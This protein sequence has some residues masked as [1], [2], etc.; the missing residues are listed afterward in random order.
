MSHIA[1]RP[2]VRLG[3]LGA[4]VGALAVAA[5]PA[6]AV[7]P[8]LG[9]Q[10]GVMLGEHVRAQDATFGAPVAPASGRVLRAEPPLSAT[11]RATCGDGSKPEPGIQGRVPPGADPAGYRCNI[12]QLGHEGTAGGFKVERYVDAAG[13]ECAYYDTTLLFPTNLLSATLSA[14]LTGVAVLD[15]SDPARPVRTAT[16]V[17]PA[18]QSPHESLV[19]NQKRGIVAAVLGNPAFGPGVVDLYDASKDCRHPVLQSSLP[20]GVLGHESGFS[21]DGNTFY[22]TSIGTGQVTAV[23]VSNPQIPRILWIGNY[24]SHG[25]SLNDAGTRAYVAASQGLIVLDTS[26]IQA[27]KPNPQVREVSRL[28][29]TS[30]TIPQNA[31]PVT[32]GGR[33][34]LVEIDEFA[35]DASGNITGL[36]S[37]VGAGRIIDISDERAPRVVSNLRLAVNQPEHRAAL[38]GDAGTSLPVQ[39]YA[40]H[41][42]GVP[43]AVEP[44]IVACSF[45]AS[46]LRVFDIRDPLAPKEIAYFVAPL[47]NLGGSPVPAEVS[48]FAM[49]RPSFVPARGEIWYSD[50]NSGFYAVRVA[51]DVWPF[52]GAGALG[53]PSAGRCVSRRAFTIHLRQPRGRRLASARVFVDGRRVKVV[54]GARTTARIDL[55]GLPRGT[56][57]VRV[58]AKTRSGRTITETR[59]YRTCAGRS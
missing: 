25:L 3:V 51:K 20:V 29:W 48:N 7:T 32:I 43:Q 47:G 33:P 53:L 31:L 59:R 42:C 52:A 10:P 24:N 39:G 58:V 18:M 36:G 55:R 37:Q 54:R 49:S 21:I 35:R 41:Y 38:N 5:A 11:P 26:E 57:T 6:G 19:V 23:D 1:G 50:G 27:R 9:A 15:M 13:H 46:G 30:M 45:I 8:G 12:T 2:V 34:Y 14:Q 40:G 4:V 56:V 17:T 44:G 28:A 22:A 16:L